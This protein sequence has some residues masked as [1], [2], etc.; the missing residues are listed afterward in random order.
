MKAA[1]ILS[2]VGPMDARP[3]AARSDVGFEL[4]FMQPNGEELGMLA[5]P[6]TQ[7]KLKPILDRSFP[8]AQ[9]REAL[10]CSQTGRAKGKVIIE[11][12]AD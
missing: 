4:F 5:D 7:G 12:R 11:V 3:P 8:L 6:I 9:T 10:D 1:I 2:I